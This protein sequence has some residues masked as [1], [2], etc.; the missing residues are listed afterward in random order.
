MISDETSVAILG[1]SMIRDVQNVCHA[2]VVVRPGATAAKMEMFLVS[3]E[4]PSLQRFSAL[5][6]VLG[7]NDVRS[8]LHLVKQDW[9]R[10]LNTID[11]QAPHALI[12]FVLVLPR[13]RDF[14][15]TREKVQLFNK[16]L[17]PAAKRHGFQTWNC[18][19]LFRFRDGTPKA[20]L[21]RDGLHLNP[22]GSRKFRDFL[23]S[24]IAQLRRL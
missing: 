19:N 24:K 20:E 3:R 6:F 9:C 16:W 21:Y 18:Q 4:C 1:D 10:L 15:Q 22:E 5:V 8:P 13:P 14:H 12:T 2:E 7:T 23:R 17:V 11:R